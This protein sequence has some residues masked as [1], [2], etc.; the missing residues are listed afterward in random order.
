MSRRIALLIANGEYDDSQLSQLRT[1]T[2]DAEQL[3]KVLSDAKIG[4]FEVSLLLNES[5]LNVRKAVSQLYKKKSRDD[6]LLLYYSGHGIKPDY[7]ELYLAVKN[8]EREDVEATGLDATFIKGLID[9]SNSQRKVVLLDCCHSGAFGEGAKSLGDS[10]GTQ[11]VLGGYG[12]VILTASNSLEYAWEGDKLVGDAELSVFTHY[13]VQGLQSGA[14]DRDGDGEV[15]P[16]ELYDYVHDQMLSA[17]SRQTPQRWAQKVE[18]KIVIART[19]NPPKGLLPAD[20]QEDLKSHIAY[21]RLGA[22]NELIRLLGNQDTVLA[23]AARAALAELQNDDSRQVSELA[24]QALN[25]HE[26]PSPPRET[27]S[28]PPK[29][30]SVQTK[31]QN[32]PDTFVITKPFRMEL[33]RVPAGEFLMGSD[34]KRDKDAR[35]GEQPQHRVYLSEYYIGKYPV[36]QGQY[37]AFVRASGHKSEGGW[38]AGSG[39]DDHPVVRVSW[40]DAVA[41]CR[42]LS[43]ASGHAIALPTEA[44]WEKAA[45]G[46]DGRIFPW[47]D[48]F[49]GAKANTEEN[50]NKGTT[51][52]GKYSPQS[53]SPYGAA[54]MA[55]NV[56][57]WCTDTYSISVYQGRDKK[58]VSDPDW[59]GGVGRVLRGGSW[60]FDYTYARCA[61][62]DYFGQR[63]GYWYDDLGF[64]VASAPPQ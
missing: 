13:L 41:F 47:G 6:L 31:S 61:R 36:T 11:D 62:R 5:F 23:A 16:D 34:P 40:N 30:R 63:P 17:G 39:K 54:D 19:P 58:T 51:P 45:R 33:V 48:V 35:S 60:I 10:A 28:P 64:R 18:G 8:T 29:T 22:A 26:T 53:D 3:A 2:R 1:P 4:G 24:E 14:A 42:W 56:W 20:L 38:E 15:T 57:E 49:D 44:Q 9:R 21:R 32:P 7:G 12:R 55:G 46:E 52:V 59:Q 27:A 25:P 43:K 50:G 37:A